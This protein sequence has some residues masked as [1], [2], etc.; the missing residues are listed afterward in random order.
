M[1]SKMLGEICIGDSAD[2]CARKFPLM[3]MGAEQRVS[4]GKDLVVRTPN[5]NLF[6]L[7]VVPATIV[8]NPGKGCRRVPKFCMGS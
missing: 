1:T 3:S 7:L 6:S 4:S 8:Q 5:G 2:I